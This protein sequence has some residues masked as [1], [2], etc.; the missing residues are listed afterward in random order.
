MIKAA[1]TD[2]LELMKKAL[3]ELRQTKAKLHA[4]ENAK[5][6]PIAIIGMSCRFPGGSKDPEAFWNML[7]NGVD[8]A[9]EVPKERWDIDKYYDPNP[10]AP[11]K[12][13]TRYANFLEKVDRFDPQ[14]FG[15]SPREATWMDPQ[16]RLLLELV[17]ESLEYA[18]VSPTELIGSQTGVFVGMMTHD[19]AQLISNSGKIEPFFGTGSA[20]AAGRLAYFLGVHGP[21]L[22]VETACSSSLVACH[23]ACQSLRDRDCNLALI[24]GVNLILTPDVSLFESRAHMNSR[25]GRCKAFDASADGIG[26]G[27]GCGV[28]VLKRLSDA[29][30]DG[31]NVLALIRGSAVNHDGPSSGLTVPYGPA[32]E[33][34]IHEALS[35]AQV[36]PVVVDYL[37]CH[38]TGTSLGDPIEVEALAAIYGKNRPQQQPLVIGSVKSNIGHTE[39]A[40]GVAG[41]IKVV[42][43]LK[44]EKIPPH[45]HFKQPN[46]HIPWA[47]LP[48]VV[49]TEGQSW[50]KGERKR[51]AGVSSFGVSGTNAHVILEE[52]PAQVKSSGDIPE[53]PLHI[54]SLSAKTPPALTELIKHYQHHLETNKEDSLADICYTAN[55]GR[56]QFQH[57][58]AVIASNQ[59]ELLAKLR[60][61]QSGAEPTGVYQKQP[62]R[63]TTKPKTAFLFTGQGSQ[64]VKMGQELYQQASVFRQA[65]DKC[66]QI[67]T[68][69]LEHPITKILYDSSIPSELLDQTEYTQPVIFALE[70]ALAQLWQSWGI[71][72]DI[73]MGHSLGEYVAACI[74]GIFSLEE[75]LKLITRRGKLMQQLPSTGEMVSVRAS[76]SSIREKIREYRE[77]VAIA[78]INGEESVVISGATTAIT[79]IVSN[80]ESEGIKTKRLQVSHPFHSPLMAPMLAEF[81]QVANQVNYNQPKIGII[82][83]VTGEKA[84]A[85]IATG[86]YWVNHISQPVRFSQSIETLVEEGVEVFLEIGAQPILLGMGRSCVST[87]EGVWLP[88]LRKGVDEW[89][90]MLC[91]VGKLYVEGGEVDWLGMERNYQR[92][93]V[94]LPTYPFQRQRYWI[95]TS[96]N[97][98]QD[99]SGSENISS[100]VVNL[101]HQ[102]QTE[103]LAQQLETVGNFS[104]SEVEL[105][106]K[107]LKLL[108]KQHQQQL[109]TYTIK[110]SL[111][112]VEWISRGRLG[113]LLPPDQIH[114]PREIEKQ[115]HQTIAELV[116]QPELNSYKDIPAQLEELSVEYIVQALQQMGWPYKPGEY[117]CVD[118]LAQR[119]SIVPSHRR[120]CQRILQ[121]LTEEK[122]VAQTQQKWQLLQTLEEVNPREKNQEL[123]T[124]NPSAQA[125]L[126]LLDRCASELSGVLRG[127]IDPVQLVFPEGDLTTAT[128]L[129]QDAPPA[130]VMNTIVKKVIGKAVEEL[131]QSR[132]IRVLEIGGGTGGTTSYILPALNGSQTEYMF[133]DIGALFTTKAKEKFSDYKFVNYQTLDIET[134]PIAQGFESNYYDIVVAANVLHAT[135]KMHQ[136]M[137]NVRKLL[138]PGGMLVLLEAT[139]R[140]RWIDLIFGMLEGWWKF[141]DY[142]LRPDY[143]LLS[144]NQWKKLLGETGFTE[145]VAIPEVEGMSETF[146]QQAVIIAQADRKTL[147]SKSSTS[148]SWLILADEQGVGNSLA[149][150]LR[151]MGQVC[152]LV[153]PGQQYQQ[154]A[155][156]EFTINPNHPEEF[157]QL[158]AEVASDS[159]SLHGVVQCW[160][161]TGTDSTNISSQELENIS[162]LGCG[163][164]LSLVQSLVKGELSQLPRLWLV[165]CGAQPIPQTKSLL[166][167]MIHSTVWGMGKA[168]NLEHPELNCVRIDL[169]P[170]QSVE[171]QAQQLWLEIWSQDKE[172]QV[173]L[174]GDSRYVARL[175]HSQ[176]SSPVVPTLLSQEKTY[177]IT[178]GLGG[179]GLLVAGWMVE[180]GAQHL[181]LVGRRPPSPEVVSQLTELEQA[182]AEVVVEQ[183]DVSEWT[184][185]NRVLCRI[186]ESKFP[187]AGVIHSAGMLSDGVLQNQ[188][189]SS[190][191]KV[192]APK[193]QGAWYLHELTKDQELDF[194]VMFSSAASLLGSPGQGNHCAANAFLDTLA[195]YRRGMGLT[196]LSIHWGAVSQVGEAA[197]RGADLKLQ[198]KGMEAIAPAQVIEALELLMSGS[199]VEVGVVPI[200]WS[201]WQ[202]QTAKS[203][204]LSECV[205]TASD[206]P[207]SQPEFLQQLE[208]AV[209]SERRSLLVA[210]VR[211][212]VGRVLGISDSHSIG[213]EQ[214]FF[215][216]GMDS[217]TSVELRNK[218][219]TSLGCSMPSTLAFDYP[220]VRDVVDYLAQYVLEV[221]DAT[222]VLSSSRESEKNEKQEQ[223]LA[224]TKELPEERLEELIDQKLN[225]LIEEQVK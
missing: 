111:Y 78:A 138:A 220:T 147:E 164:T 99:A 165:T 214:G 100:S 224:K 75:G 197:A 221:E 123:L 95:D 39:A 153:F 83:N 144:R 192:M 90:S 54:L 196:G 210:H 131:P 176:Y 44:N 58:L 194:F 128:S 50:Q 68:G 195:H 101:I 85:S 12:M 136:T 66:D 201:V 1:K 113:K 122:I 4:L 106:P 16:Q 51:L 36:D 225:L 125:E 74:A 32:Q 92:Q 47:K 184:A 88:S 146:S 11:G 117:F 181:V 206:S 133:T 64:Y 45:L 135:T 172:E 38:G 87:E 148:K 121:I 157:Q 127:A 9:T 126:K 49:P 20:T 62:D 77:E 108:V 30:A 140:Q 209:P 57:R 40:A 161:M 183:A 150:Q 56:A 6:E 208:A 3:V 70:Y 110:D 22:T 213:L 191:E 8:A 53:R 205:N 222:P 203:L 109:K 186:N 159:S 185:I 182:G 187:L 103:I 116:T 5:T 23:L 89:E 96:T 189:W 130:Q 72:P 10:D 190:F 60:Q 112:E 173:G 33:K 211:H 212:Q 170:Q 178:G 137:T 149:S 94:V 76:E 168:I 166:P 104:S 80:L 7:W 41:L 160:T 167:G 52:A 91:S 143:P 152:T 177:L 155:A 139:S 59:K 158:L 162:Q 118:E 97:Q 29:V 93:K 48:V 61:H 175:V 193:V 82:S 19:Y 73:V 115:L 142:D 69:E 119:L 217:L 81:E 98:E 86:K 28:V 171:T 27:E 17:W 15:I 2:N 67:L 18:A 180:K 79:E 188:S 156:E 13:Y 21:T 43:S 31:D 26:R 25:D 223:L 114:P 14:F 200:D 71:K 198:D 134:D 24:A 145:V 35:S 34:L 129:Y 46:P 169:D 154:I 199:G 215:D 42:L 105:L 219:Q 218:L 120:L 179:L 141:Q 151:S 202:E 63:L 37:E 65:I 207:L 124:K 216:L 55:T 174:R 84:E 132:G 163:S 102:G 107:V 204:F